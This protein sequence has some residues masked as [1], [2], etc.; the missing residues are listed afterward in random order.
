ML[1]FY[2]FYS[3]VWVV[4][5]VLVAILPSG[6]TLPLPEWFGTGVTTMFSPIVYVSSLFGFDGIVVDTLSFTLSFVAVGAPI[7]LL[8]YAIGW[9]LKALAAARGARA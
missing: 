5:K 6:S 9:A 1:W 7:V 4:V 2:L 8:A 3:P